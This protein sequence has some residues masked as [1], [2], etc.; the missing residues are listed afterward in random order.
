M[1][2]IN[3]KKEIATIM[4]LLGISLVGGK[5]GIL[6][7]FVC[8]LYYVMKNKAIGATKFL[9]LLAYRSVV[10]DNLFY[11][12]SGMQSIKW[13][14]M[15]GYSAYLLFGCGWPNEHDRRKYMK[16]T[17]WMLIFGIYT[18]IDSFFVSS[19]PLISIFKFFSYAFVFLAV[20]KGIASTYERIDWLVWT[21]GL[22]GSIIVLSVPFLVLPY[23]F[24]GSL[25][26][27]FSNQPNML[28]IILVL[29]M[30]LL[31]SNI[32][33]FRD[34]RI[35]RYVFV[36]LTFYMLF[37]TGAR[38]AL[39]SAVLMIVIGILFSELPLKMKTMIL[40]SLICGAA[41]VITISGRAMSILTSFILKYGPNQT[42]GILA[43]RES[44]IAGLM[45][46]I[47]SNPWFG[48]GFATP[49]LGY[50]LYSIRSVFF[51]EPGNLVLAILSYSGIFGTMIFAC[52][53]LHMVAM[54][55]KSITITLI[56]ASV[57][58]SMGEMVYF[59]SNSI[60]IWLYACWGMYI[61]CGNE[62][63]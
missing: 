57:L 28:G 42:G 56:L 54:G 26:K 62:R 29:F 49:N 2:K 21:E 58:V 55:R 60:A 32:V 37:R 9:L 59:S 14:F 10:N 3:Q 50:Q 43:S 36:V 63:T 11:E 27:G 24:L 35:V 22:F 13:V 19:L 15:F 8:S 38:T 6:A 44:Q 34:K 17:A 23:G 25:F 33:R 39:L 18:L 46:N 52:M 20:V 16:I 31:V 5:I 61:F 51:M 48:T 1:H 30:A 7:F 53:S 12:I 45:K 47:R 41:F 4:F 40:I